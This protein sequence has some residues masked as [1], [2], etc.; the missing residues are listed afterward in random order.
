MWLSPAE[1]MEALQAYDLLLAVAGAGILAAALLPRFLSDKPFTVPLAAVLLGVVIF[2][3]PLG[4]DTPDPLSQGAET[5]RLTELGVIVSLMVGGLT[6]DRRP[7]WR[8]WSSAWRLLAITMPVTVAGV[9]L[10]GWWAGFVPASA[11]LLGAVLA[12]TDPVQGKDV[13]VGAPL[14][15]A[16][17]AET[18]THDLTSAGE[19][20]EVRFALTAEAGMNDGL[21][22]PYTNL[23]VAM[24]IAGARPGNWLGAWIT[25]DVVYKLVVALVLGWLLGKALGALLLRVPAESDLS[26]SVTALGA[27]AATLLVYGTTE[28]AGGYGFIATFI[29]AATI[30]GTDR[31]HPR[32]RELQSF[33]ESTERV[34]MVMIMVLFGGAIARGLLDALDWRHVAIAALT[35]LVIR[36]V[37]GGLAMVGFDR[38]PWR[39]RAA[40][41]FFGVRGIA[42]F[43]YLSYALEEAE[44]P[45][46]EELW[47][48]AG[49]VVL[50][51]VV[52]HGLTGAPVL[53]RLDA[54]REA[55]EPS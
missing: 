11:V 2:S 20:D 6:I 21:A 1:A 4:F 28:Y 7:G 26:E 43:Y 46:K 51:S 54:R 45:G 39:D 37:A 55:V 53:Q 16:E 41:S 50:G 17:E 40:I 27:L 52:L 30:R 38:A 47:A 15:G 10:L 49:L 22:F 5:E 32:H 23:A 36:P 12:P 34:L 13:E 44:F 33:I 3:L 42:T 14:E 8:S 29:G 24:A 9:A 25:V 48:T 35:I 31:G 19:E 18:E